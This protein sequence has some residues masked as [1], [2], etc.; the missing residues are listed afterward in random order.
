MS[1]INSLFARLKRLEAIPC[2]VVIPDNEN[3]M[4]AYFRM[5]NDAPPYKATQT[6]A[7]ISPEEAYRRMLGQES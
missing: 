6:S 4:G 2:T 7:T 1:T 5:L 3:A